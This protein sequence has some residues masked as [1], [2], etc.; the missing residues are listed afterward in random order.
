MHS[1]Q[2]VPVQTREL[3]DLKDPEILFVP[4][5]PGVSPLVKDRFSYKKAK[6]VATIIEYNWNEDAT[7]DPFALKDI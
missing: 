5:G 2:Q 7:V 1:A 6:E 3:A 4:G